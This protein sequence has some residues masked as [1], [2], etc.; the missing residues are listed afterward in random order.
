MTC[1][2]KKTFI[3]WKDQFLFSLFISSSFMICL[4]NRPSK[5]HLHQ[6]KIWRGK[7]QN[8]SISFGYKYYKTQDIF[9]FWF[10]WLLW[11]ANERVIHG[12]E[13]TEMRSIWRN[14]RN[15]E[16]RMLGIQ[17]QRKG[18]LGPKLDYRSWGELKKSVWL[19]CICSSSP[20]FWAK[21]VH[22]PKQTWNGSFH[23]GNKRWEKRSANWESRKVKLPNAPVVSME[24]FCTTTWAWIKMG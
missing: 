12:L 8:W 19:F 20:Q 13:S 2:Y 11:K 21:T 6:M 4:E 18:K 22:W 3:S 17:W 14:G 24:L 10:F 1:F 9:L 15:K 5:G 23:T 16:K 7:Y